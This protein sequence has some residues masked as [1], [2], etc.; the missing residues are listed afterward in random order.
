[1]MQQSLAM[2]GP[3][4]QM[5]QA[6]QQQQQAVGGSGAPAFNPAMFGAFAAQQQQQQQQQQQPG[7]PPAERFATQLLAL[8]EMGF[9]D[10]CVC[11][12]CVC[13][14]VSVRES[15]DKSHAITLRRDEC[16][17]VLL[18]TNGNVPAAVDILL[19]R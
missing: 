14:C 15:V 10:R 9:V 16:I 12:L 18:R 8:G 7:L 5:Q 6:Q 3:L 13:V 17:Q 11:V 4:L 2:L 19:S 1:M